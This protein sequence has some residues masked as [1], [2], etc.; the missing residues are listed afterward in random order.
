MVQYAIDYL[1][2]MLGILYVATSALMS[3]TLTA[4]LNQLIR[5]TLQASDFRT[6]EL[7]CNEDLDITSI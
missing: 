6:I 7:Y 5:S 1:H 4:F 2:R 3:C